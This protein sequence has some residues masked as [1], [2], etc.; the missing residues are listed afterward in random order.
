MGHI[1]APTNM[2]STRFKEPQNGGVFL[3]NSPISV[4]LISNNLAIG[5]AVNPGKSYLAA[6]QQLNS[7]GLVLG[8]CHIVVDALESFGQ[9]SPTD[10][11]KPV[12]FTEVGTP[13]LSSLSTTVTL[14]AGFYRMT[15]TIHA[16]NHQPVVV[17]RKQHGSL[18][19]VVYVRS[20]Q[21]YVKADS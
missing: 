3:E 12:F 15:A 19:D 5:N 8:H 14:P 10:P 16:A 13:M 6:P 11:S 18:N 21:S 1:P 17:P 9:Q 7:D 20:L 4:T 2:P